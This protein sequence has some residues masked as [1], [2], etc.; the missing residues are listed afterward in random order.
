[1]R[2]MK[3]SLK[4]GSFRLW[5]IA[6]AAA[7][8]LWHVLDVRAAVLETG[9]TWL[10]GWY[11][12]LFILGIGSLGIVAAMLW[13]KKKWPAEALFAV[14]V[15][16][17]GSLY[18]TVLPPLSAPDEIS[19][20]ISSYELSNLLMGQP[21][22][23]QDGYIYIRAQDAFI[24]DIHDV[25]DDEGRGF[26][27]EGKEEE[28]VVLGQRLTEETYSFYHSGSLTEELAGGQA[29]SYQPD[30]RTTPL[31]YLP[32]A[33]GITLARLL[34]L[35][36][37][38]LLF[39][40]RFFNLLSYT[41]V[42]YAAVRRLPFGKE[43]FWA[44]ALL[45]MS[46]HL[47]SSYSYD[48]MLLA[49]S[50]FFTAVCLDL[51]FCEE[52]VRVRDVAVLAAV[53]AVMGPCKMVYGAIAGFCLLIPVRKFG[54]WG[55]WA[56]SAAAVLG[57]FGGAMMIV[58]SNTV[59]SY[60]QAEEGYI[61]WAGQQGYTFSQLLHQPVHVAKMCYNT[62]MWQGEALY[63]GMIGGALGNQDAVLNTPYIIILSLTA[64][65]VLL[66]LKKPEQELHFTVKQKLW[67]WFICLAILGA[68]MFSMLLAWTP[69]SSNVIQGVQGRY[70]LP[71][72]P[73]FLLT[74]ENKTA[75]R[76][77]ED[78]RGLLFFAAAANIYVIFRLFAVVCLRIGG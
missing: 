24:E 56:L 4:K 32:Q 65:L 43:V 11:G 26:R 10:Y 3:N 63:S 34:G 68:L 6:A 52:R 28:P 42:G 73:V 62:L 55:G 2:G 49:M 50:A 44:S 76:G 15:L 48:A 40:G 31:A 71:L 21:A 41:A 37:L 47:V 77:S 22:K 9:H 13:G 66:A 35:G 14:S 19:H 54:G 25:L 36:G 23:N 69:V 17:F 12:L 61:A 74:L 16:L 45:P 38:G 53:M 72:L 78:D 8:G 51:A 64:V 57:A 70:L 20:F 39:M 30:V 27:N 5:A 58:N 46:L 18:M 29:V 1:M 75:V 33:L 60:A 7:L 67:I 59:A